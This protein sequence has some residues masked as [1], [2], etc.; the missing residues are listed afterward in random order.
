[1]VCP[2][3]LRA[4]AFAQRLSLPSR[5]FRYRRS[6]AFRVA[7]ERISDA[8]NEIADDRR[9][10]RGDRQPGDRRPGTGELGTSNP[11]RQDIGMTVRDTHRLVRL[12]VRLNL[13]DVP[14]AVRLNLYFTAADLYFRGWTRPDDLNPNNTV[15]QLPGYDLGARLPGTQ[16]VR[17]TSFGGGYDALEPA[18]GLLREDWRIG[19]SRL[20]LQLAD[21]WQSVV[22]PESVSRRGRARAVMSVVIA[23]SEAARFGGIALDI[24]EGIQFGTLRG[25]TEG[26]NEL[27]NLWGRISRWARNFTGGRY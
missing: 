11:W 9:G 3:G 17:T 22:N 18:A 10:Q 4:C 16:H 21:L 27:T 8:K 25:L 6:N 2:L 20:F 26:Q 24:A 14:G 15:F 7:Q 1:V 13:T 12:E 23:F 19:Q 5:R